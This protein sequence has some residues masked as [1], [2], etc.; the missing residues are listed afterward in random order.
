MTLTLRVLQ[1]P[2]GVSQV[3]PRPVGSSACPYSIGRGPDNDWVLDDPDRHISKVHCRIEAEGD[4]LYLVDLSSNGVFFASEARP[5]GHGKRRPLDAGDSFRIGDYRI[6][7]ERGAGARLPVV[8]DGP[9]PVLTEAGPGI[10]GILAGANDAGEPRAARSLAGTASDWLGTLPNGA[11]DEQIVQPLGWHAPPS[12][13]LTELPE[14]LAQP[15]SEFASLS[16]H[17]PA[18]NAALQVG[19]ARA[20]LPMDWNLGADG[21]APAPPAAHTT[22]AGEGGAGWHTA[23]RALME[24]ATLSGLVAD[25]AMAGEGREVLV[26]TGQI[27]RRLVD[28]LAAIEAVQRT[29]ERELGLS[30]G[31][32]PGEDLPTLLAGA[33]WAGDDAATD[34]L[35]RRVA[36]M[37][38]TARALGVAMAEAAGEVGAQIEPEAVEERAREDARLAV[39]PLLRAASWERYGLVHANLSGGA[40]A[41]AADVVLAPLRRF[42]AQRA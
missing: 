35:I 26:R 2:R 18:V 24:G 3:D 22:G 21:G 31:A 20:V 41:P 6:G 27:L 39:G 32:V 28:A 40:A 33:V 10:S 23:Q 37:A 4:G 34:V 1:A 36:G 13:S 38:R 12:T 17:V 9:D 25:A 14:D 16:E 5:V 7:I 15:L 11:V 8:S 42:F 29:T 19:G 30:D